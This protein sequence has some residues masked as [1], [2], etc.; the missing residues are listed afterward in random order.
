MVAETQTIDFV[1]LLGQKTQ[2]GGCISGKKFFFFVD[3]FCAGHYNPGDVFR[4]QMTE[5]IIETHPH[6]YFRDF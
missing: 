6:P 3:L 2:M 5:K 1:Y 4:F